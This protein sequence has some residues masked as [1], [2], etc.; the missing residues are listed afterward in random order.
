M[1][2]DV[3]LHVCFACDK[4]DA[5]S[6]LAKK[7]LLHEDGSK[8]ARWYPLQH[9]PA[10]GVSFSYPNPAH[11]AGMR[12]SP[13]FPTKPSAPGS[14]SKMARAR[15]LKRSNRLAMRWGRRQMKG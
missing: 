9:I 7:H 11:I 5:V 14:S 3:H 1:A 2:V 13:Y 15:M 4:N 6:E 12:E 10:S 8:E